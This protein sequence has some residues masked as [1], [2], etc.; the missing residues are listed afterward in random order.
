MALT[1]AEVWKWCPRCVRTG[2]GC[3]GKVALGLIWKHTVLPLL[4]KKR[5]GPVGEALK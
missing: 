5:G 4:Q 2:P 1:G 3:R